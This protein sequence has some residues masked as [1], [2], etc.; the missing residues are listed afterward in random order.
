MLVKMNSSSL[1]LLNLRSVMGI[2]W[3]ARFE[4]PLNILL[5]NL[6]ENII[7]H[8]IIIFDQLSQR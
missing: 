3:Q 4:S 8:K 1:E 2:G 7:K 5:R 6:L